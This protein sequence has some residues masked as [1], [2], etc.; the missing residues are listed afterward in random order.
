MWVDA[1]PPT[2]PETDEVMFCDV[3]WGH[4]GPDGVGEVEPGQEAVRAIFFSPH[5][6]SPRAKGPKM[7]RTVLYPP[8]G[9]VG[10]DLRGVDPEAEVE[11]F[12]VAYKVELETMAHSIGRPPALRWGMIYTYG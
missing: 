4:W 8:R 6:D 5:P 1:D 9:A 2:D 7:A 12:R 10:L 3:L 11:A